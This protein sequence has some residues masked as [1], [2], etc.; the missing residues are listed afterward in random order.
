MSSPKI[1][2]RNTAADTWSLPS[3][4]QTQTTPVCTPSS[5]VAGAVSASSISISW[6]LS[7]SQAGCHL[8]KSCF[9]KCHSHF[10]N[11]RLP[12]SQKDRDLMIISPL[13]VALSRPRWKWTIHQVSLGGFVNGMSPFPVTTS[14]TITRPRTF[15]LVIYIIY[16]YIPVTFN[17]WLFLARGQPKLF[18]PN[19]MGELSNLGSNFYSACRFQSVALEGQWSKP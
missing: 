19:S 8:I 14:I 2:H 11:R 13:E 7:P 16:V 18:K 1:Q 4:P 10:L 12:Q 17:Y 9:K 5:P 3:F 6:G 15:L